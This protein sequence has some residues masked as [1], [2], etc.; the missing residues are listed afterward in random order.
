MSEDGRPLLIKVTKLDID[1]E[2]RFYEDNVWPDR[3]VPECLDKGKTA[4]GY[5]ILMEDLTETHRL[6]VKMPITEAYATD[7]GTAI[8]RLHRG[9]NGCS[10]KPKI[11]PYLEHIEKGLRM[12]GGTWRDD[13]RTNL[14]LQLEHRELFG[15]IHGDLNPTNLLVAPGDVRV[16]DRQ[17]FEW[18]IT[19]WSLAADLA[20]AITHVWEP[21]DRIAH[22]G[23]AIAAFIASS[24]FP[25]DLVR[26]DYEW[27]RWLSAGIVADWIGDENDR[28]RMRWLWE[29]QWRRFRAAVGSE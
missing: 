22:E 26:R 28:E 21:A 3:P 27:S 13:L 12:L 8:G 16:I 7:L 10:D 9:R 24:G 1:S 17:P 25:A 6:A 29:A 2:L 4:D 18:S 11:E 5:W 23:T 14:L 15:E 19:H 20:G